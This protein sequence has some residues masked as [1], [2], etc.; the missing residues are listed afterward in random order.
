M[1]MKFSGTLV[2]WALLTC[3][4][5]PAAPPAA[6]RLAWSDEFNGSAVDTAK[7]Q[8]RT[9]SKLW[10]TQLPANVGVADGNLVLTLKKED[11]GGM[12]YTG[13][14]IISKRTF[15][16]GYY[17]CRFRI[18]AGEG[19][20]SSFWLMKYDGAGGTGTTTAELEL[21]VIENDSIHPESY[22]TTTHKWPPPH[23][24]LGHK[25]I[26]TTALSSFRVYGCEYTREK[27]NYFLD[28]KLVQTVD[29]SGLPQGEL[30]IWLTSIAANLGHT[31]KVDDGRLPGHIYYDY[32]H[33]YT[34]EQ[35]P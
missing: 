34:K 14:G 5:L 31:T 2:V 13:G 35:R 32:V 9:D 21:D 24:A 20:H 29:V 18:D 15:Q 12:H 22:S 7:W 25:E 10:S 30:N 26:T 1:K 27:V 28:D 6:Y 16:Y 17:E 23:L 19:W 11:A 3:I 8:Y 33:F 4:P